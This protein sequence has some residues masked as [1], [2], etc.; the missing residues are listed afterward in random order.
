MT[1][2]M[3]RNLMFNPQ[4]NDTVEART[5]IKGAT[6]AASKARTTKSIVV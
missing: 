6:T 3:K 1:E 5:I 4:G 2:E